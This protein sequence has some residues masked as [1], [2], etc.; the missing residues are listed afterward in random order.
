MHNAK[1]IMK[2]NLIYFQKSLPN[3]YVFINVARLASLSK[4]AKHMGISVSAVSQN[5]RNLEAI[6]GQKLLLRNNKSLHLTEAGRDLFESFSDNFSI[7]E[8]KFF[9]IKDSHHEVSGLLRI[10]LSRLAADV[11]VL[12]RLHEFIA[13]YPLLRVELFIDDRNVDIIKEGFDAGI[14]FDNNLQ[15]GF[16]AQPIS[17]KL[18]CITMASPKYISQYG[19]PETID[20]LKNHRVIRFRLPLS[21]RLDPF[22]FSLDGKNM[23]YDI[24]PHI[25]MND[26]NHIRQMLL[27]GMGIGQGISQ[28]YKDEINSGQLVELLEDFAPSFKQFY[29]YYPYGYQIPKKLIAFIDFFKFIEDE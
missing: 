13:N 16:A 19:K 6:I 8:G 20:D 5:L 7:L 17:G 22:S 21:R 3:I 27:Q 9:E 11:C 2:Q 10:N 29:I 1:L 4:A 25:I 26:N 12:P 18:K 28:L 14:R 23:A 15:N 24:E